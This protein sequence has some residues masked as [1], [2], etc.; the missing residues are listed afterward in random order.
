[1]N[2][3]AEAQRCVRHT[4]PIPALPGIREACWMEAGLAVAS[5]LFAF[6]L[7]LKRGS[8]PINE[9]EEFCLFAAAEV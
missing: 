6:L 1:M 3:W 2:H 4:E 8:G 9:E 7:L 5:F